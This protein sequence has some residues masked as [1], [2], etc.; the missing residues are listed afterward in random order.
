MA[1]LSS[2][3]VPLESTFLI[4]ILVVSVIPIFRRRH[5]I[6]QDVHS[7]YMTPVVTPPLAVVI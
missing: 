2:L 3:V 4:R 6:S 1:L 7:P 5:L